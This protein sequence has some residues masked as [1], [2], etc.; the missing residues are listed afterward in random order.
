VVA[1]RLALNLLRARAPAASA[2]ELLGELVATEPDPELRHLK[3]LHRADFGQAL[4]EA[5]SALP[6]RQR[7]VLRL[8]YVDGLRLGKIADLYAVHEST[9]SRWVAAAA[10][11]VASE[12]RRRLQARLM[13]GPADL[14]SLARMVG[15]QLDLSISRILRT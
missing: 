6:E 12:A 7:A 3:N 1:T 10:G 5:L 13:V 2:E 9:V 8:H 14:D 11:S 4:R 15:S